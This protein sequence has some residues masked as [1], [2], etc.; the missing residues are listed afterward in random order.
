M[1]SLFLD[2][3]GDL[4]FDFNKPGTTKYFV[5]TVLLLPD[6][7][8]KRAMEK[9]VER[10][11]KYKISPSRQDRSALEL[12]G[13]ETVFAV[14]RYFW[15]QCAPIDFERSDLAWYDCF[16]G[17]IKREIKFSAPK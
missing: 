7:A 15:R 17:K 8:A 16:S 3:S 1:F 4:D 14:K 12:K 2:E 13:A 5:E 6:T 11:V 10:T 9:A